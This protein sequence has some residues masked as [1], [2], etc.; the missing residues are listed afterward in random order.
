[1]PKQ[2]KAQKT[3]MLRQHFKEKPLYIYDDL[4]LSKISENSESE[5][6]KSVS[7]LKLEYI[8]VEE[9]LADNLKTDMPVNQQNHL[10]SL[11]NM[12]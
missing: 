3:Q 6:S 11:D 2:T 5:A 12:L 4:G 7:K 9:E 8:S 10:E 1:M